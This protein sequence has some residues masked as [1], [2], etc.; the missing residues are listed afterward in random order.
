[1]YIYKDCVEIAAV[2]IPDSDGTWRSDNG[3]G[4]TGASKNARLGVKVRL[5]PGEVE[6]QLQ[7]GHAAV[8]VWDVP[9]VDVSS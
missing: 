6:V 9:S 5:V 1:M 7:P 8:V 4:V 2:T 3:V